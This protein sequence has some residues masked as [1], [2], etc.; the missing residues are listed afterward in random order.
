MVD[1]TLRQLFGQNTSQ[2]EALVTAVKRLYLS[3]MD[4]GRPD[5]LIPRLTEVRTGEGAGMYIAHGSP[6]PRCWAG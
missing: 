3:E 2:P 6:C 1:W 4:Y 5:E